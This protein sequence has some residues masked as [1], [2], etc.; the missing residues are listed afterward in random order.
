[1]FLFF[2]SFFL[3]DYWY[4]LHKTLVG[5][6]FGLHLV[7]KKENPTPVVASNPDY[8]APYP[9]SAVSGTVHA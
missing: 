8:P 3:M 4:P 7:A 9:V 6:K 5:Q 1:M 2:L